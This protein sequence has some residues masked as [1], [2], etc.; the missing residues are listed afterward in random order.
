[1]EAK[2]MATGQDNKARTDESG[3]PEFDS[4]RTGDGE[5]ALREAGKGIVNAFTVERD[6]SLADGAGAPGSTD[7]GGMA[8]ERGQKSKVKGQK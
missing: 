1:M 8:K 4:P 7:V 3:I 5:D 2:A 6:T